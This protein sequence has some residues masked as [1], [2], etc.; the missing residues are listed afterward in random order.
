MFEHVP[1]LLP[2]KNQIL[3]LLGSP[4]Q[5]RKKTNLINNFAQVLEILN[6]V[7][8]DGSLLNKMFLQVSNEDPVQYISWV[9]KK[10]G[11]GGI[12]VVDAKKYIDYIY[13]VKLEVRIT[14]KNPPITVM[15]CHL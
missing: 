14:V 4:N 5:E 10:R 2:I 6:A 3:E 8:K 11:G 1:G 12:T 7:T 13:I 15:N 9:T